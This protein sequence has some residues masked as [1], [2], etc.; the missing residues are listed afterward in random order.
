MTR[1]TRKVATAN[2]GVVWLNE[3]T[4]KEY[5]VRLFGESFSLTEKQWRA[6]QELAV[7]IVKQ[8]DK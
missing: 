7:D 4:T 5:T 1:V 2:N 6:L 8:Q 3:T